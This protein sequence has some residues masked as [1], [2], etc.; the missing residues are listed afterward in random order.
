MV[1]SRSHGWCVRGTSLQRTLERM[2]GRPYPAYK[3]LM[4]APWDMEG[5]HGCQVFF[6]RVQ[7]DPYAPPSWIRVR[8][9]RSSAKFPDECVLHSRVRN[10]ALC[11]FVT[12]VISDML[13]GGSGTDWTR[14]VSGLGW[15]GSKGGA[16][17]IDAPGQ[18]VLS[19]TS[20]V[21]T[22]GF[23]EARLML[24][25]P[26]RGRSIEGY[27]A[28]SIVGGLMEVIKKSLYYEA[29]DQGALW[30]HILCVEDQ[31]SARRQL[32]Q[33]GLVAFVAN[34]SVLPRKSGVDDRPLTASDDPN[35]VVF[36]SPPSLETHLDLPN[37][38]RI[39]GMRITKGVTMIVGGG[40]HGKST[41]LQALQYGVYDK[42]EGDG[43]EF[44][45][46]DAGAMKIRAED[47]RWI[48]CTNISPFINNL[49]FGVGTQAFTTADASGSTSQA[50]NIVEAL[51]VGATVL[52]IDEDT[53]ATNFMIRDTAMVELVAPEK[54]PI[55][56]F[57]KKVRP[58]FDEQ[59]VSTLMVIG[60][61]GDFF[62]VADTVICMERYLASDVTEA[63]HA[64]AAKHGYVAPESVPFPHQVSSRVLLR[65]GLAA[66]WKVSARS[67]RCITYGNTEIELTFVE[68]LVEI[69]QVK[70]IMAC[71]QYL[72]A[73]PKYVDGTRSFPEVIDILEH[74]LLAEGKPLGH[75]GLD[76]V[77]KDIACPFYAMPRRFEISAAINRL[78]TARIIQKPAEHMN[79]MAKF[80][81]GGA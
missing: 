29:L 13:H 53:C 66:D 8:L 28:S 40:F 23:A 33:L 30:S 34:G 2:E 4:G 73:N 22:S 49:P 75:Q 77:S 15:K 48:G 67:L 44:V 3:D 45:V 43:R 17:S 11:D 76:V 81:H 50:A 36:K 10:V 78:R 55:T 21:I 24:S 7:G 5:C 38:G 63:A 39:S 79:G 42:V 74:A 57:I 12:R 20:V 27:R 60:G 72:A 35:L 59:N 9:P 58:L 19:R 56:P 68:Q 52:L 51:E 65:D 69:S 32:S 70:A 80:K 46:C 71:I 64:V 47:G 25:L 14:T 37:R 54:E 6:D 62:P 1:E 18:Y 41:L 26:A 16:I 61:T 31:D